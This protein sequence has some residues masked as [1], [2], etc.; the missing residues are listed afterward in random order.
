[1][2]RIPIKDR[3]EL[4]DLSTLE[5]VDGTIL[6]PTP[7]RPRIMPRVQWAGQ[8]NKVKDGLNAFRG[9]GQTDGRIKANTKDI[10]KEVSQ[11]ILGAQE[12]SSSNWMGSRRH[13]EQKV[14]GNTRGKTDEGVKVLLD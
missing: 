8:G 14:K 10:G 5:G 12:G 13:L 7:I 4:V 1:M 11:R 3:S 9:K 2:G 6:F